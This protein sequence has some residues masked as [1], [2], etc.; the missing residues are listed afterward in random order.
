MLIKGKKMRC[1]ENRIYPGQHLGGI[2]TPLG[3]QIWPEYEVEGEFSAEQLKA[4]DIANMKTPC[5]D[6]M[7]IDPYSYALDEV[8]ERGVTVY[9][10]NTSGAR[11][12]DED[13]HHCCSPRANRLRQAA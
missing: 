2:Y 11:K 4:I 1:R 5:R 7:Y 6:G 10:T 8:M 9:W 12:K 3:E 13:W